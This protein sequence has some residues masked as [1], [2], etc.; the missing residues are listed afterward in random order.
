MY[1]IILKAGQSKRIKNGHKWVFS[2]EIKNFENISDDNAANLENLK[3]AHTALLYD[4]DNNLI[5]K[6]FFNKHSLIAF[7][8]ISSAD[9]DFD[10]SFWTR[11]IENAFALRKRIYPKEKSYRIIFGESD[12]M[13][14]VV[15]DKYEDYLCA[16]FLSA[17]A[18]AYKDEIL[19]AA[20]EFFKPKGIFLRNDGS[21][22]KL[23]NL[24]L[25]NQI[26]FGEIPD[27]III[28]ENGL[29]FYVDLK[30]G[31][32]TGFF[33][34][35]RDNRLRF[36]SY[37]EDKKVLDCF[38]HTGAFG[39]YAKRSLAKDIVFVDSSMP[40]L[41]MSEKNFG[42]NGFKNFN[43][44][45]A[46]A[47]EYLQSQEAKKENFD[48][49]NIDPPGLVKNKKDFN[50]GFKHYVKIH[51]AAMSILK[52]GGIL[53]TSSCCYHIDCDSFREIISSAAA[54]VKR[55]AVILERGF[56]AKDHP[57]L[58]AMAETQYLNYAVVFIK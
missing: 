25:E 30:E 15:I 7:R 47:L 57:V 11:R 33:F 20:K 1:K 16:Q 53:S 13:S 48:I 58:A 27:D 39:I 23:E 46:D 28:K 55:T 40:A 51:E 3:E 49:V 29:S 50:A 42:L 4:N 36:S 19:C 37:T 26:Y 18:D 31:Q 17:G 5:G 2:N 6:G 10:I 12:N 56:A 38:C 41:E 21:F 35:Q 14:G 44:L 34:D 43:G 54:N 45:K 52:S 8:L 22:R 24:N 9:E 32:K